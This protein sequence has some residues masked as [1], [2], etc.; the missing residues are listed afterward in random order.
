MADFSCGSVPYLYWDVT[1]ERLW[2]QVFELQTDSIPISFKTFV[3]LLS[4]TRS[5][6]QLT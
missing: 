2:L 1:K 6:G 4:E 5:F 3:I